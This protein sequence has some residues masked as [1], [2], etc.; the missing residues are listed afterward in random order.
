M[1][2]EYK[3]GL[4]VL[5]L[6]GTEQAPITISGPNKEP[7]AVFVARRGHNTVS[8]IN[9]SYVTIRNLDLDG[10][11][12]PVDGVKCEGHADWAHHITLDGLRIRGHGNNQQ[13]VGISTKCPAWGWVIRNSVI[14]AAG[15]GLYLGNSDGRAPFIAGLIEH[16]LIVDTLGYNLQ[17][18]HQLSRPTLPG[19]PDGNS[20][21]I[22]RHNV[23]SKARGG[24]KE[25]ARPNMLVGHWPLTGSGA[26]DKYLIYGNFF[27]QN[28]HESLFQGE[29]NIALYNN[30]FVNHFGDA[31]Q[32]QPHN[33]TT[34]A[35]SVFYNTVIAKG[36]GITFTRR[37]H[38][39][40]YPQFIT[41]NI[42]FAKSPMRGAALGKNLT[43]E[44]DEARE[45]LITPFAPLGKMNLMPSGAGTRKHS[46]ESMRFD[47]YPEAD[48]DFD[49]SLHATG[50]MGA[51]A[52]NRDRPR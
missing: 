28:P 20:T 26:N 32:I 48:L 4:P 24:S 38:D 33:D 6:H 29:G 30:L 27:Y 3:H 22:I 23:F 49:G 10:R 45:Y 12:L 44:L 25:T 7:R 41:A 40:M 52:L 1:P 16:N 9:S 43:G 39:P 2:G 18:K 51:Y 47:I 50:R 17:I 37:D 46:E 8:I 19:I 13:T 31:M 5:Y 21:T 14:E 15:T 36:T 34:R 42:V 35:I 11:N